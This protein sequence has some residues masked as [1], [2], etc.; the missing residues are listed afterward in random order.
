[1]KSFV[2]SSESLARLAPGVHVATVDVLVEEFYEMPGNSV[3]GELHVVLDDSNWED[4]SID[5]CIADA[6]K[7]AD[8]AAVALGKL[9]R[10]M[11]WDE[12][13]QLACVCPCCRDANMEDHASEA[14]A[15]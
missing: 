8:V 2:E 5:E 7:A 4:S 12:R 11:A 9:L 3:G 10:A 13:M 6:T 14:S 15:P 1:M